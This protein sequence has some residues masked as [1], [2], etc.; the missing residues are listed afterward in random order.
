M[1]YFKNFLVSNILNNIP[2]P[3]IQALRLN[4]QINACVTGNIGT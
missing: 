2:K 4:Q 1:N 3:K